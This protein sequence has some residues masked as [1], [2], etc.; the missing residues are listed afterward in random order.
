MTIGFELE[1]FPAYNYS[2]QLH[3]IEQI[4]KVLEKMRPRPQS[5]PNTYIPFWYQNDGKVWDKSLLYFFFFSDISFC[6]TSSET[7]SNDSAAGKTTGV[8]NSFDSDEPS[9]C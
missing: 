9:V 8:N 2:L 4:E 7:D 6:R 1:E 3:S 5:R